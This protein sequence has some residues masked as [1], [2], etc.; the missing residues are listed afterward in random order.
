MAK[1]KDKS[2][3]KVLEAFKK[4]DDSVTPRRDAWLENY[5]NYRAYVDPQKEAERAEDGKSTLFVPYLHSVVETIVPRITDTIL[6]QRPY[7]KP[8]PRESSDIEGAEANEVLLD[9]QLEQI[10][11]KRKVTDWVKMSTIFNTGIVKVPWVK[12][13]KKVKQKVEKMPKNVV[14]LMNRLV[15]YGPDEM[16]L[17]EEVEKE[18]TQYEGPDIE[19]VDIFDFFPDPYASSVEDARYVIHRSLKPL[20]HVKNMINQK[21]YKTT[22]KEVEK[23]SRPEDKHRDSMIERLTDIGLANEPEHDDGMVEILEYW[24]DNRVIT[25]INRE[26]VARDEENPYHHK[27]KPFVVI[28][29]T[30]VPLEFWGIGVMEINKRLQAEMNTIRNQRLDIVSGS[31]N[32]TW[33]IEEGALDDDELVLGPNA[34]NWV[35]PGNQK[36][37]GDKIYPVGPQKISPAAWTEE[38]VIKSDI[39]E[40]TGV[41]QYVKG[42]APNGQATATEITSLQREA[43][44]RF[45]QKILNVIE[46]IEK[47]GDLMIKLN[48]QFITTEQ[49][50]RISGERADQLKYNQAPDY[51]QNF[52]EPFTFLQISPESIMGNY[53]ISVAST[54]LEPL[55]D[56]QVKRQQLMEFMQVIA[57]TTG[58]IPLSLAKEIGKTYDMPAIDRV[59]KEIEEQQQMAQQAAQQQAQPPQPVSNQMPNP[60]QRV[61]RMGGMGV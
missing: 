1:K 45:K 32:N 33:F 60:Q 5:Q 36:S 9:Y 12:Q 59:L 53:D 39:Q 34:I 57:N 16:M 55:A 4:A 23:T 44:Y 27:E 42:I 3:N 46:G 52:Q 18:V 58:Q 17:T 19:L 43:N 40:S 38:D 13:T 26:I 56:K 41:T 28:K 47:V 20:S 25:L 48:Q 31:I 22:M 8:L 50:I 61:P 54:A 7:I 2:K 11:F 29:D 30:N 21:I 49:Y 35:R 37:I 15:K 51:M 6:A 10:K 24:E 14:D